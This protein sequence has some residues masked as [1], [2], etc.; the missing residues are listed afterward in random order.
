MKLIIIDRYILKEWL[1]TLNRNGTNLPSHCDM[2]RTPGIDMTTGSL[3]Q[4][5]SL[6]VGS[7]LAMKRKNNTKSKVYVILGDGECDEGSVWEAAQS[8]AHYNCNQLVAI[9]DCNGIQYD[10]PTDSIMSFGKMEEKWKAFG[11]D[12]R[13]VDGH[14][15]KSLQDAFETKHDKPLAIIANTVKGKGVSYMENNYSWHGKAPK[16][17]EYAIAEKELREAWIKAAEDVK[18]G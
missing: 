18:N 1:K 17:D 5:L 9:V 12:V 3:G 13:T 2:N 14:D 7:C 16:D 4:G 10:G 11:W 6:G 15:V 8:A